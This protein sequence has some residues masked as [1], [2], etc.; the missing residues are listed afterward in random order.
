MV[1]NHAAGCPFPTRARLRILRASKFRRLLDRTIKTGFLGC[2]SNA[3]EYAD[4]PQPTLWRI[5]K[6]QKV[7]NVRTKRRLRSL[8]PDLSDTE[9]EDMF[10]TR[11]QQQWLKQYENAIAVEVAAHNDVGL[12][13]LSEQSERRI[14]DFWHWGAMKGHHAG[15]IQLSI[16]RIRAPFVFSRVGGGWALLE[17]ERAED[18]LALVKLGI[19]REKLLLRRV[20]PVLIGHSFSGASNT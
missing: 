6:G 4:I 13:I 17:T 1:N 19:K 15:R 11:Q 12:A 20:P 7:V 5:L 18:E 16:C 14:E 2:V 9:W 10:F 8:L 3:A